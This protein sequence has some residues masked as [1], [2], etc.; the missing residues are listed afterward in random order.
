MVKVVRITHTAHIHH[1]FC[2]QNMGFT[3]SAV[4]FKAQS[5]FPSTMNLFSGNS[6]PKNLIASD[7]SKINLKFCIISCA[8]IEFNSFK[9]IKPGGSG[10]RFS[11]ESM[12][13]WHTAPGKLI[14][15]TLSL[16]TMSF[17]ILK[18]TS[19]LHSIQGIFA[20]R[21]F[22]SILLYFILFLRIPINPY[23]A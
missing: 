4:S 19:F 10:T 15:I 6:E 8:K 17:L 14:A 2:F 18:L 20:Y 11:T 23:F 12:Q 3:H 5:P 16:V 22:L 9:Q 13:S 1:M 7:M 21:I